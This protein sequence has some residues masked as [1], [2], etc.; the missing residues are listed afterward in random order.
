MVTFGCV[1]NGQKRT[2]QTAALWAR[3]LEA[4]P[5][6]RLLLK[7][8]G[9]EEPS[10][11][12][13]VRRWLAPVAEERIELMGKTAGAREHLA[14]YGRVDVALD[15]FPYNGTTTTCESLWM[16]VPVVTLAGSMHCARVGAS[17]LNC[18]GLQDLVASSPEQWM[19]IARRLAMDR[20]RL[21]AMRA[22][23][24]KRMERSALVDA[25]GY[26]LAVEAKFLKMRERF[27][28]D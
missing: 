15:T 23:L 11:A 3:M 27:A 14:L 10:I 6:S 5:N 17:L 18:V 8:G 26:T 21:G 7:S 1:N 4:M 13:R 24:R 19:E 20:A 28:A 12:R 25:S 16:G 22:G 9:L 2:A